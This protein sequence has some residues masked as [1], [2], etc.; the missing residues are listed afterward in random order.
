MKTLQ[1]FLQRWQQRGIY[2]RLFIP[3]FV[4]IVA[5]SCLRYYLLIEAE[6]SDARQRLNTEL[7]LSAHYLVPALTTLSLQENHQG[8]RQ[9]LEQEV[10]ASPAI[11]YI[12]WD[13][14]QLHFQQ[15]GQN[16][17]ASKVPAW[18]VRLLS[19]PP[20]SSSQELRLANGKT[21]VLSLETTVRNEQ[22]HI[23]KKVLTQAK[24]SLAIIFTIYFLLGLI[25]RSNVK[26]LRRLASAT[27]KFKKGQHAV[28]MSVTGTA[29]A[30]A[31]A[32]T[33]NGMA[34]EVQHLLQT[35]QRSQR[36]NSEQLHFT[37]Q[38]LNALPIPIFFQDRHGIC[39]RI[40]RA[41][42]E[43]FA[44]SAADVVGL[45]MPELAINASSG[46]AKLQENTAINTT[47]V[48][49][50]QIQAAGK[51]LDV[52]YY[53]AN[54]TN[55]DGLAIGSIG[56]LIDISERNQA[57]AMLAAENERVETTLASIGDAVISTD[58]HGRIL[59]L[60][61]VAQQLCGWNRHEAY[62]RDLQ[63]VFSLS[64]A[65]HRQQ[66]EQFLQKIA[67]HE[68]L[69]QAN[70]QVL[71]ARD[72]EPKKVDYT[73]API[74][75]KNGAVIGCVLVFRDVSEKHRLIQQISWQ[76]GHDVLTG[77]ENRVSLTER[78]GAAI[79][80][81]RAHKKW[82]A[83]CLIDLDHFQNINETHG[84]EF[85]NKLLQQVARRLENIAGTEHHVARLGG[86]EFVVLLQDQH[87]LSGVELNLALMLAELAQT[88][89]IE[90][91]QLR[92][93]AS[94][95]V[96]IYPR[97]DVNA[98]TLLRCADQAMYQAK[99]NGRNQFHLFDAEQDHQL[100]THHN[101]R[102]RIRQALQQNEMLLYYQPKVDMQRGKII[103]MEALLRWQHPEQGIVGPLHFLPLIEHTDLINDVGDWV[104]LQAMEELRG[105]T[106]T[107]PEW[108]LSVN[109]AARHFQCKDF[110]ERLRKILA[111][112]PDVQP[113][114]LEIEILESA[115]IH[116]IQQVREVMFACQQIGVSFALDDFGTGYSS[117]SYLKS[118]PANTLKIDQSFVR[119]MLDDKDD[120]AVISAVIGLAKAFN[121]KVI[122]EGVESAEHGVALMQLGCDLAQGYGVARPMPGKQVLPWASNYVAPDIWMKGKNLDWEGA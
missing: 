37:W 9:L 20:G 11:Q 46:S 73:A 112:Y 16:N 15:Q 25:L 58:V 51:I 87:S 93:S 26:T 115:A 10:M 14:Q 41:W 32:N 24:I 88:Y 23:W 31:L 19:L 40:N 104:L 33:F 65:A 55:V 67:G 30:R 75:Q 38:L 57:Q 4:L 103:G 120:L 97:D 52:I 74:R 79:Q 77:L 62:G 101:Q 45:S 76:A 91:Q 119:D 109:I 83:V 105:W 56:A 113:Q 117:L 13:Y 2:S 27:E 90:Q 99:L 95:G 85:A 66:L 80:L 49:E 53:Q 3:I 44:L 17:A 35:L 94:I 110:V 8:I 116:D 42:E 107:H 48:K 106:A 50:M 61:K 72:G 64:E 39:R 89:E 6:V 108:V 60:N 81:A 34:N 84:Q 29:E 82:L 21:A 122:A 43:L 12:S 18:F 121:R 22:I 54:F 86:D 100:R 5:V 92:L 7:R 36:E 59:M 69:L 111:A 98:D 47:L 96:A 114:R 78:F 63:E 118:L 68:D 28:R 1:E 71:L 102:A 70:L